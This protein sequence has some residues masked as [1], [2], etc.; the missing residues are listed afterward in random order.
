MQQ[1]LHLST[2]LTDADKYILHK[3]KEEEEEEEEEEEDGED[4]RRRVENKTK[5]AGTK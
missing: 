1:Y 2:G 3:E 4:D 5:M